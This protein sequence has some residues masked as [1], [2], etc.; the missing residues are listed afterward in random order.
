[1]HIVLQVICFQQ[2]ILFYFKYSVSCS[3]VKY[4]IGF[5]LYYTLYPVENV[6]LFMHGAFAHCE[7]HLTLN[8]Q[9]AS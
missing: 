6:L 9:T 5:C 2:L 7:T 3:G 8:K 1:M 4:W